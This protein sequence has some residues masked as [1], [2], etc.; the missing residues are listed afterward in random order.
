[1]RLLNTKNLEL[2]AKPD[3]DIPSYAILSHTWGSGEV[4]LQDMQGFGGKLASAAGRVKLFRTKKGLKKVIDAAKLAS[5]DGYEWIWIDTCCIDKTS[6]AELSEAINSMYRW[7]ENSGVCYVY[8]EDVAAPFYDSLQSSRAAHFYS[9]L[10]KSR[11]VTRGWTLQ[12]LIAP[13]TVQFHSQDWVLIGTKKD[14]NFQ[15]ALATA[16]GIEIGILSGQTTVAEVSVANRMKWAW[17]RQTTRFEDAAYCLIGIFAVNMPLLYGEGGQRAF[18]R[19]Q[20]EIL[21]ATDDQSIFAW[22]LP[23]ELEESRL[24]SGLL[25][26]SPAHFGGVSSMRPMLTEFQSTSSVPWTMTNKGLQ[27]QL[28][29][30]PVGDSDEEEYLAVLDCCIE[31]SEA[32][33][34]HLQGYSP[35]IRLRKLVGDQYTRIK[36]EECEWVPGAL[37]GDR[38]RY[39]SFFV[40]QNPGLMLPRLALSDSVRFQQPSN[41]WRLQSVFPSNQWIENSGTFRLN[42]SRLRGIQAVFRFELLQYPAASPQSSTDSEAYLDQLDVVIVLKHSARGEMELNHFPS[43]PRRDSVEQIYYKLNR[44]W[45][46]AP[47]TPEQAEKMD[48]IQASQQ[49]QDAMRFVTVDLAN[50]MRAGRGLYLLDLRERIYSE[51]DATP[52]IR[53][54]MHGESLEGDL[55]QKAR[56]IVIINAKTAVNVTSTSNNIKHGFFETVF[57]PSKPLKYSER[58]GFRMYLRDEIKEVVSISDHTEFELCQAVIHENLQDVKQMLARPKLIVNSSLPKK[59]TSGNFKAIHFAGL[60]GNPEIM[61]ILVEEGLDTLVKTRHGHTVLQLASML[62]NSG[63]IQPLLHNVT[64]AEFDLES[65]PISRRR[66]ASFRPHLGSEAETGNTALHLAAMCCSGDEFKSILTG[67]FEATGAP[68]SDW[69]GSEAM[70]EREYLFSL[71]NKDGETVL[72]RAIES[73]NLEV[74]ELICDDIPEIATRLDDFNRSTVWHTASIGDTQM[75]NAVMKAYSLCNNPPYLHLSDDN[76][77]TPL[78]VACWNGH[79]EFVKELLNCGG[80]QYRMT[81]FFGFTPADIARKNGQSHVADFLEGL[82]TIDVANCKTLSVTHQYASFC[83]S[84]TT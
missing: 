57:R 42:H 8:L 15:F 32:M 34:A 55:L 76:G 84:C 3:D 79:L 81:T 58:H 19:L 53:S 37:D 4:S 48:W 77:L 16:T 2:V 41:A 73:G 11:W 74:V 25:A 39:E 63:V 69:D 80:I 21:K 70:L 7:Y 52:T 27:V 29:I 51:L 54:E 23:S 56:A 17:K 33:D 13:Q 43:A 61:S 46:A 5:S 26:N 82:N 30:R 14:R 6:S 9:S 28:Y 66:V 35:S 38:G 31:D 36:A 49:H 24:V 22:R 20:E 1:M 62:G 72:H 47:N 44:I 12:E 83:C 64:R 10:S 67:L 65:T 50:T 60:S 40:K 68:E 78:H 75:L 71:R 45:S 18:I 59:S